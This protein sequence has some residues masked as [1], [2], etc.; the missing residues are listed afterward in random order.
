MGR[1]NWHYDHP[2]A[3]TCVSCSERRSNRTSSLAVNIMNFLRKLFGRRG[4]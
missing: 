4:N 2:P 3:C 1:P